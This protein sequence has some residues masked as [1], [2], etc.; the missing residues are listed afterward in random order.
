MNHAFLP[1]CQEDLQQRGIDQLDFI[2]VT[3]DAYVDHPSF[4]TAL[5]SRWIE[6]LGYTVGIISQP[7]WH[8]TQD[9]T[10]LGRPRYAFMV[11]SGNIDSMVAHYSVAKKRRDTDAYSP[12]GQAGRRP[13]R[14][15]IVYCNR[16]RQAYGEIPIIIG[17]LEASLRRFAHYDYWSDSV[18]H[19][20]LVDSG[21]DL[22]SYGMGELQAT[23]ICQRLAA[24]VPVDQLDSIPGTCV[25]RRELPEGDY[26]LCPS[27]EEVRR[28]KKAYA[29][30]TRL[31][32][33]EQ[34]SVR[35]RTVVQPFSQK[36]LIQY[37]PMRPLNQREFDLVYT[38]PYA[39]MWHPMYD[40]LGGVP[41]I[42]EVEFSLTSCRGCFGGCNFCSLAFH[43]GRM[44]TVRSH[45]SLL[46]EACSFVGNPRFKGYIH[47][48]GGPSANFRHPSCKKQLE[49]GM[50]SHRKCLAP[51]PCPQLDT[52]HED[53]RK[54]LA[55]LRALPGIKKVFV[56]SGIRYDYLMASGDDRFFREL[57]EHHISGQLKVAPE[58]CSD[59]TLDYMG[60]PHFEVY[61]KFAEKYRRI[62]EQL[63]KKQFLVPYLMSSHPGC[64]LRDAIAL[65]LYLKEIHYHPQQVQDFY[66]TP[67]TLSTCMFY[68]GLDPLTMKEVYV[69]RSNREKRYQRALLQFADPKNRATVTEALR[70][71]G[72]E[73]LIGY[74]PGCLIP[75]A[76]GAG[77]RP[78]RRD[79]AQK[80]PSSRR[81]KAEADSPRRQRRPGG[82]RSKPV[83]RSGRDHR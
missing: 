7:D 26:V 20:I 16:I 41:A 31:Q 54:L 57:V 68:T 17:G 61:R 79:T 18:R 71:A 36:Y 58:H 66:P 35:G 62:N 14:A 23:A 29:L 83:S 80:Q 6:H 24:G 25:I 37:P 39:R 78:Q 33:Q 51:T 55:E 27:A 13:D 32:Y 28:D 49:H 1:V 72:R 63:G 48:V 59:R 56:R 45:E 11:N 52:S 21:A 10:K 42:E 50:C 19:S 9:F 73:D 30:A 3:G 12:G 47:D 40:E 15:V 74:G 2:L 77:Q 64:T 46:A 22:L 53:Y 34:D 44:V 76:Y 38:L 69:P 81:K 8:S 75:P 4:G 65:A 5:I 70:A 82:A 43:Q 60:K 67:G